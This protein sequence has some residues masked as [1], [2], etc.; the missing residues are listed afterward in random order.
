LLKYLSSYIF[1]F[2][3]FYAIVNHWPKIGKS[4][5]EMV[6]TFYREIIIKKENY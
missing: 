4:V 3:F 6:K 5:L 2:F 1:A